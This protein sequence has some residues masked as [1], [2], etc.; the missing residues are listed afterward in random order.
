MLVL[1]RQNNQSII[2]TTPDGVEINIRLLDTHKGRAHLGIIAPP[3]YSIA[4]DE[5]LNR[6]T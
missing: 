2:I 4:R 1:T 6:E 3:E 5:L